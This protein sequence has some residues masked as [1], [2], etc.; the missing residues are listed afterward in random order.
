MVVRLQ[1]SDEETL[2]VVCDICGTRVPLSTATMVDGSNLCEDC[3]ES[4]TFECN[5]CGIRHLLSNAHIVVDTTGSE[6][7]VCSEC[8]HD[9]WYCEHC[10]NYYYTEDFDS[11]LMC[12]ND[13]R[14]S[15]DA[16]GIVYRDER[17]LNG[18]GYKPKPKFIKD[19][20][21]S[22]K[23][24]FGMEIELGDRNACCHTED[25]YRV[26]N[27]NG[28]SAYL[29][30]DSSICGGGYECVT[31][32]MTSR[33]LHQWLDESLAPAIANVYNSLSTAGCGVHIHVSRDSIG[34][35]TLFKVTTMLNLL[36]GKANYKF[37]QFLTGREREQLTHWCK[38]TSELRLNL[39]SCIKNKDSLGDRY[40]AVNHNNLQ[41]IEFRLFNGTTSI[42]TL[43]R[44][45]D[46]LESLLDYCAN[47]A[48]QDVSIGGWLEYV[49][50]NKG[51]YPFFK[52]HI[53]G[54]RTDTQTGK[55]SHY[56][57]IP[58][59]AIPDKYNQFFL[60]TH[61]YSGTLRHST[62][63]NMINY[64]GHYI[65]SIE[66][67]ILEA[68]TG[69]VG[70]ISVKELIEISNKVESLVFNPVLRRRKSRR[71]HR[72]LESK[73]GTSLKKLD[74]QVFGETTSSEV[75]ETLKRE[76]E[77]AIGTIAQSGYKK[78]RL[79]NADTEGAYKKLTKT[80]KTKAELVLN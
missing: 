10:G 9:Y 43:H 67:S 54:Q 61:N 20:K 44:Y 39:L 47:T 57:K 42:S 18:Y 13:C 41:T 31:H 74:I 22:T 51:A 33:K 79:S 45:L 21:E 72:V 15:L 23:R 53:I 38:V 58:A 11:D 62:V 8:R 48:L 34:T 3:L 28:R 69:L 46:I 55:I 76:V 70:A 40:L 75:L 17:I 2:T 1:E 60:W 35:L 52:A 77:E 56:C 24:F 64:F 66:R 12:C 80:T 65:T 4:N 5:D 63:L 49:I 59:D 19:G 78:P 25:F 50:A 7:D 26:I 37:I 6:F 16:E 36:R 14:E 27:N 73:S 68:Y 29:K 71:F 30:S 32:P